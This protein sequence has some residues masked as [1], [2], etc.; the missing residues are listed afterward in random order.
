MMN[1]EI[2]EI[3]DYIDD[4][5]IPNEKWEKIKD[6]ITNLQE[7]IQNLKDFN[8]KLQ[9]TKDRLD[10][11]DKENQ[12]KIDKA[13]EY[14]KENSAFLENDEYEVFNKKELLDILQGSDK[15]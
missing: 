10:K 14:I 13:I 5:V 2:K 11:Y 1:K 6:Y 8:K 9:A 4:R 15:E 12:M 3:I 7:E